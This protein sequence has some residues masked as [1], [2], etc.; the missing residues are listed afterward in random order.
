MKIGLVRRGYSPSGGAERY[1]LRFADALAEAGHEALLFSSSTWPAEIWT[2]SMVR[3][4]G[5]G[6][7]EFADALRDARPRDRCDLLFSLERVWEC[8]AYRAGDGVHRA[9]LDRRA[10][11]EPPWKSWFRTAR[12]KH[13]ELLDLERAIFGPD[14]ARLIIANSQMVAGEI[15]RYFQV[16]RERLR[17]IHNGLPAC[18]FD[19][20]LPRPEARARLGLGS[21]CIV[22]FAGSGWERKGLRFAIEAVNRVK[23][24]TLLVAGSGKR[25]GLPAS[26]A[27]RFL[28]EVKDIRSLMQAADIFLL[29]TI[30]DPF[31]NASLEAMAAGVPVITTKANG[32]AEIMRPE[33]GESLQ[34]PGDIAGIAAAIDKW[35]GPETPE[36]KTARK[37]R[38]RVWS[39]ERNVKETLAMFMETTNERRDP[40]P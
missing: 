37:A 23:D 12:R 3:V 9:W 27:T 26:T 5:G 34:N 7:L 18:S 17:V 36:V 16:P 22:L 2:G 29:P 14:G 20:D 11:L 31:S 4:E 8:D 19:F 32:F 1:L 21:E 10:A 13:R 28:G 30:Y 25:R 24:A 15:E 33:D 6:P 39:I 38:A 35:R 40:L